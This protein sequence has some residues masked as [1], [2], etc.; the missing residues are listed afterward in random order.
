MAVRRPLV[1]LD[2]APVI[3]EFPDGDALLVGNLEIDLLSGIDTHVGSVRSEIAPVSAEVSLNS[4]FTSDLGVFNVTLT[5]SGGSLV[6]A[7][8]SSGLFTWGGS[9][10]WHAGNDGIGSG[11]DSDLLDG[12]QGS[13][14]LARAN[15]TGTQTLA[16]ISDAGSLA[17]LN[18]INNGNWSGT[19]LAVVNGGTGASDAATARTNLGCGTAATANTG[20]SGATVPLLNGAN[21]HSGANVF[22]NTVVFNEAGGDFDYRFEGDTQQNL[23]FIDAGT[24]RVGIGTGAPATDLHVVSASGARV[25][26]ESTGSG[27]SFIDLKTD[28]TE[29]RRILGLTGGNVLESQIILG[30]GYVLIAGSTTTA[31]CDAR[32]TGGISSASPTVGIGYAAG[33]GGTVTQATSKATGV[34]LNKVTGAIT[35]HNAALAAAAEVSFTLTNST[36]GANDVVVVNVKSGATAATYNVQVDAVAAGS[37]RM[38][39]GNMSTTSRSEAIVLQFVVVKGAVA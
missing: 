12:W 31:A 10:V 25:R 4:R 18:T 15:H 8:D 9:T 3:G 17:A 27:S 6:L 21:T 34:T 38:H 28:G 16:T 36:I 24:D 1:V 33:A 14:Y 20:T 39:V 35:M 22:S 19:D 2:S 26:V 30:V 37:C 13:A 23:L 5:D 7:A 11:L 32:I 29:L